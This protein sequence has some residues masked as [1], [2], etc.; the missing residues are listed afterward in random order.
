MKFKILSLFISFLS[1][2]LQ[3]QFQLRI[4]SPYYDEPKKVIQTQNGTILI[5]GKT[6]G[7]GSSGN[8]LLMKVS[9]GGVISWAK[10]YSGVNEDV[11]NDVIELPDGN[12][13]M[14]GITYSYGGGAGDAFL[15]KTDA[16]GNLLWANTYGGGLNSEIFW[17]VLSDGSGGFFVHALLPVLSAA[18]ATVLRTDSV[19]TVLWGRY[20]DNVYDWTCSDMIKATNGDVILTGGSNSGTTDIDIYRISPSGG[21]IWS[22][23]Y[24]P[25]PSGGGLINGPRLAELSSGDILINYSYACSST[26]LAT[27]DNCVM[28]LGGTSGNYISNKAYGGNY[29]DQSYAIK[30]TTDG[31]FILLG[32]TNSAG[33]GAQ[34]VSLMKANSAGVLQWSKAYGTAWGEGPQGVF[35]LSGGEY[36][37]NGQT[38]STGYAHDSVKIYLVKT[39]SLGNGLCNDV[40]WSPQTIALSVVTGA[41]SPIGSISIAKTLFTWPLNNRLMYSY[42]ICGIGVEVPDQSKTEKYSFYPNPFAS[43]LHLKITSDNLPAILKIYNVVGEIVY[44]QAMDN[45]DSEINLGFLTKGVYICCIEIKNEKIRQKII[46]Q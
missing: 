8:A 37:F 5:V 11:I 12:L 14:C 43:T 38:I 6:D 1:L 24:R 20:T 36:V 19:G 22:K 23:E 7:F 30:N 2:S 3:A 28:R 4:G 45:Y 10:D 39:D 31:G 46:K 21:L 27:V 44:Q 29:D 25:A 13:V 42:N 41:P 40:S 16:S 17:K 26:V 34:D 15:M 18:G 35:Q 33:N 9:P 32:S